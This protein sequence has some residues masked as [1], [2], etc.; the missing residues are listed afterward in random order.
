M[1]I[2]MES[3]V[4]WQLLEEVLNASHAREVL[5]MAG[6]ALAQPSRLEPGAEVWLLHTY[7][8]G[9][10]EWRVCACMNKAL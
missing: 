2:L 3:T 4:L 6:E 7:A 8:R 10:T 1:V 9:E 5:L